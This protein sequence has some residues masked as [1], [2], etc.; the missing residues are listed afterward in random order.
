MGGKT[1]RPAARQN[2]R[3]PALKLARENPG[4]RIP[5]DPL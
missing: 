5:Y 1:G 2:I 4:R 3:A